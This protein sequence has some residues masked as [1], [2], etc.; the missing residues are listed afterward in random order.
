MVRFSCSF[1]QLGSHSI[2]FKT[3]QSHRL[4]QQTKIKMD[5]KRVDGGR[6]KNFISSHKQIDF[7]RIITFCW[8]AKFVRLLVFSIRMKAVDLYYCDYL[9]FGGDSDDSFTVT[10]LPLRLSVCTMLATEWIYPYIQLCWAHSEFHHEHHNN[11][12]SLGFRRGTTAFQ[13]CDNVIFGW[14]M[15]AYVARWRCGLVQH[16]TQL[17]SALRLI[18]TYA[19]TISCVVLRLNAKQKRN[20]CAQ[21]NAKPT[22]NCAFPRFDC[23]FSLEFLFIPCTHSNS[24]IIRLWLFAGP[25][26]TD[27]QLPHNAKTETRK[28]C[29]RSFLF[30]LLCRWW[31]MNS[32]GVDVDENIIKINVFIAFEIVWMMCARDASLLHYIYSF[33]FNIVGDMCEHAEYTTAWHNLTYIRRLHAVFMP[34]VHSY[35]HACSHAPIHLALT[36]TSARDTI[37]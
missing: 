16:K 6:S 24:L 21:K 3:S 15:S 10:L 30:W 14:A 13:L 27:R 12:N 31:W 5:S 36:C 33:D 26:P 29:V 7:D 11:N 23:L 4:P 8:S 19:D 2:Q 1:V 34:V 35:T 37:Q 22:R 28:N 17:P 20:D 32:I 9:L 18:G 25:R